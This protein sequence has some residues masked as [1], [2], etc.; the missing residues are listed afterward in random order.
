[1]TRRTL[2]IVIVMAVVVIATAGILGVQHTNQ[3]YV[4]TVTPIC[5]S[6][7]NVNT[8]FATYAAKTDDF[9][10]LK[11]KCEEASNNLA[12]QTTALDSLGAK[13]VPTKYATFHRT[14]F[15][16]SVL[17]RQNRGRGRQLEQDRFPIS[18][19]ASSSCPQRQ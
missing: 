5:S 1:M 6:V 12:S 14:D 11:Q 16:L 8:Q 18:R 7:A 9:S 13:G 19:G 17:L 15:Q 4:Q 10:A 3:S 2:V